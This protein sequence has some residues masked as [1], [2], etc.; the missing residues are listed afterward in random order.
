MIRHIYDAGQTV[1]LS[2][3]ITDLMFHVNVFA[4]ADKYDVPSLR[5]LV[6]NKFTQLLNQRWSTSQQEFCTIVQRLCGPG[7][8]VFADTSLQETAAT[9]CSEHIRGLVRSDPFVNMLED[10]GPFAT[11]IL[12]TAF[13]N[14]HVIGVPICKGCR[15]ASGHPVVETRL[16]R[17]CFVC[18]APGPISRPGSVPSDS[19]SYLQY[20][21]YMEL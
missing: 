16:E 11:R 14:K 7:A 17:R 4:A 19:E 3:P 21:S 6:I 12:T 2:S 5:L 9:F 10:C 18:N 8:A 1:Y 15:S 13:N 20:R